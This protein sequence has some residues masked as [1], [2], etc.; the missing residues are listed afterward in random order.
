MNFK[1]NLIFFLIWTR[2][3]ALM[4]FVNR[5]RSAE[6]RFDGNCH[7]SSVIVRETKRYCRYSLQNRFVL[8]Q[9]RP[10]H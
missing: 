10:L 8:V 7:A 9:Q 2:T 4:A 6:L 5:G 3:A 1:T